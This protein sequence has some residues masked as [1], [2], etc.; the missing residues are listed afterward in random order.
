MSV[1]LSM[2][3]LFVFPPLSMLEMTFPARPLQVDNV[4]QPTELRALG[5][6]VGSGDDVDAFQ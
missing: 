6:V 5:S 4:C 1:C 2:S 3:S